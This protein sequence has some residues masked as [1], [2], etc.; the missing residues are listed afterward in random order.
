M[1]EIA[2]AHS[3]DLKIGSKESKDIACQ[4]VRGRSPCGLSFSIEATLSG[5]Q[6]HP[7]P[8]VAGALNMIGEVKYAE[9][10]GAAI[11]KTDK[12]RITV[13]ANGHIMIIAEQEEAEV[14]LQKDLRD[15]FAR[16]DVHRMQDL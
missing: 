11:I 7:F 13:F 12:G 8:A 5:P 9:D 2:K 4:V 14:L 1:V 10:L 16:A 6:N 15:D 3:I